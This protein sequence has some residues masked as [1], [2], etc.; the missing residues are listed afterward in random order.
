VDLPARERGK[1]VCHGLDAAL[2]VEQPLDLFLT[3]HED[4]HQGKSDPSSSLR[5]SPRTDRLL[6]TS[7]GVAS[8]PDDAK[9]AEGLLRLAD[10]ALYAA[11]A[12]GRNR[13]AEAILGETDE[14][15]APVG[16]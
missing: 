8:Y 15:P 1:R 5:A 12:A 13:V 2:H 14:K 4:G 7:C 16:G 9:D 10:R 11:K 6:K 3:E